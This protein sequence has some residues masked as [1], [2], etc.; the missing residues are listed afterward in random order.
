MLGLVGMAGLSF[1]RANPGREQASTQNRMT[2]DL[3]RQSPPAGP[4]PRLSTCL[5]NLPTSPGPRGLSAVAVGSLAY[6]PPVYVRY[7]TSDRGRVLGLWSCLRVSQSLVFP[8][9]PA[10]WK[11]LRGIP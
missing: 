7:R 6:F 10:D 4:L 8:P 11:L 5:R 9:A 2:L 1:C 3:S